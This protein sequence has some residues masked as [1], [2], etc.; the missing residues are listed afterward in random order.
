[1]DINYIGLV[2]CITNFKIFNTLITFLKI[3][4]SYTK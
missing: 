2:F 4:N 1:M 3:A